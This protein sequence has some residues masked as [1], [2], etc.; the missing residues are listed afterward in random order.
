MFGPSLHQRIERL[1]AD[2]YPQVR[3][4]DYHDRPFAVF[5]YHPQQEFDLR[6]EIHL[7]RTRLENK[8]KPVRIVC[9]TGLMWE[10]IELA[11][12]SDGMEA[13][14]EAERSVGVE[15]AIQT[16][17]QILTQ[18]RPLDKLVAE[19]LSALDPNHHIAFLTGAQALFPVYRTSSLLDR[20]F[21]AGVKVPTILFYPGELEG[22]TG[23]KF[24]GVLEPEHNY[25]ARIY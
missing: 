16:V 18:E 25:R 4:N 11:L 23:L 15:A 20:L 1:E 10:C 2:L 13:F 19:R 24:M 5:L 8:G 7:L 22:V 17:H 3:I 6:V 21:H 12:G 14:F 9:L